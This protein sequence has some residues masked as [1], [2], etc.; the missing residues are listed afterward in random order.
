MKEI[1]DSLAHNL[2]RGKPHWVNKGITAAHSDFKDKFPSE[3]TICHEAIEP[4]MRIVFDQKNWQ[5]H[6]EC[7]SMSALEAQFLSE[8]RQRTRLAEYEGWC[9]CCTN[10]IV[11]DEHYIKTSWMGWIHLDCQAGV[12]KNV[13]SLVVRLQVLF[14]GLV[15]PA[16]AHTW[17]T[18]EELEDF[19]IDHE[20]EARS[21]SD[22]SDDLVLDL[23]QLE[24]AA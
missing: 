16:T 17:H 9:A 24:L 19:L 6:L 13:I 10:P 1:I 12:C 2:Y 7:V 4:G 21:G 5:H 14:E 15:M 3:C 23:A 20:P 11:P 8:F 18:I 22:V